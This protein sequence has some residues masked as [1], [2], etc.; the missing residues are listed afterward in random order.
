M[1]KDKHE[2]TSSE[3]DITRKEALKKTGKYAALTAAS[4]LMLLSSKDAPA[5]S[6][7]PGNPGSDC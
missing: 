2:K 3:Q 5:A 1:K 6:H 7:V 4:M